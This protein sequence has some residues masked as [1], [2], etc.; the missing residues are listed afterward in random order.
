MSGSGRNQ[1][2]ARHIEMILRWTAT[3]FLGLTASCATSLP[4]CQLF[5]SRDGWHKL[6]SPPDFVVT[7]TYEEMFPRGVPANTDD[8]VWYSDSSGRYASC[9]PGNRY[10]C[11]DSVSYFTG[12]DLEDVAEIV[13]CGEGANN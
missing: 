8:F 9:L 13:L 4:D 11:G 10:G 1:P 2:F 12:S 3:A 5:D 6:G 7:Q